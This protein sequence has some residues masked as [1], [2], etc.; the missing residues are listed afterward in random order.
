MK[1]AWILC[2]FLVACSADI[3]TMMKEGDVK[4]F[5]EDVPKVRRVFLSFS[6]FCCAFGF[7]RLPVE[8][9]GGCLFLLHRAAGLGC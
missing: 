6:L 8:H 9:L 1:A 2:V 4:C 5:F 7:S 3:Y